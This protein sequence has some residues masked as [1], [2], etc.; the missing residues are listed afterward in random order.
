MKRVTLSTYVHY[1]MLCLVSL[2]FLGPLVFLL[3]TMFKTNEQVFRYPIE[4]IPQP[5]QWGNFAKLFDLMPMWTFIQNSLIVSVSSTVFTIASCSLVAFA[6]ARTRAKTKQFWFVILLATLMIPSQI[7]L[8]PVFLIFKYLG[9][10]NTLYSLTIPSLF[11]SAFFIF[12][13]RQF[14]MTIPLE[15][16]EAATI[17]GA[18][19]WTIF[20]RMMLPLSIPALITVA[21]FTFVGSWTD[22]YSPLIYLQ[23]MEKMT[24]SV[25]IT[26]LQGQHAANIPLLACASFISI[27]PIALIYTFAQ[28]YFVEGVVLSGIKG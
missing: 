12:L 11:G 2:V 8:I 13:L 6:F 22:F 4:W 3:S 27:V 10:I 5:M 15:L 19:T 16:D 24:L 1:A 18:S 26:F 17:D 21:V 20:T 25:G 14:Y 7:T 28:R 9:W 23:S